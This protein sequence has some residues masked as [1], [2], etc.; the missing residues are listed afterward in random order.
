MSSHIPFI[1]PRYERAAKRQTKYKE[2]EEDTAAFYSATSSTFTEY[3][4]AK[5]RP[6][7]LQL[8]RRKRPFFVS[9]ARR[10]KLQRN[11]F[12]KLINHAGAADLCARFVFL[13]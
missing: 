2:E 12:M 10:E 13:F 1:S 11:P 3:K 5:I 9:S 4:S 8:K 6:L 7:F